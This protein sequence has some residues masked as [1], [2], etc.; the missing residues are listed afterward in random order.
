MEIN[1][2][3]RRDA[4]PE[5]R[6]SMR[7]SGWASR[8]RPIVL[9]HEALWVWRFEEQW[10]GRGLWAWGAKAQQ[11]K[12][13]MNL[14]LDDSYFKLKMLALKIFLKQRSTRGEAPHCRRWQSGP[15][16]KLQT[17]SDSSLGPLCKPTLHFHQ[18]S[19]NNL[20]I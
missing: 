4:Y 5:T 10:K 1:Q 16:L 7:D 2:N 17:P 18:F 12:E 3:C 8:Q 14:S 11:S 19:S 13:K 9:F 15:N 20:W 6:V